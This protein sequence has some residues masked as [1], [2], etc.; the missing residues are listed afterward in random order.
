MIIENSLNPNCS[1]AVFRFHTVKPKEI[2]K[3]LQAIADELNSADGN[4]EFYGKQTIP[5]LKTAKQYDSN[6]TGKPSYSY[7]YDDKGQQIMTPDEAQK[8]AYPKGNLLS[9]CAG[10][11]DNGAIVTIETDSFVLN[12][13]NNDIADNNTGFVEKIKELNIKVDQAED[14]T[15]AGKELS[16]RARDC[17]CG[18]SWDF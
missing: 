16:T 1:E 4:V 2:Q 9:G 13:G 6:Y 11:G 5:L 14:D 10:L 18:I 12:I 15:P 7:M 3:I 17:T 8:A